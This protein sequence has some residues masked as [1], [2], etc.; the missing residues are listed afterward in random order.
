MSNYVPL[1]K[2]MGATPDGRKAGEPLADATSPSVYAPNLGPTATHRSVARAIDPYRVPNGVTFNQ[3]FNATTLMS[4]RELYK[5]S[6]LVREFVDACGM[7]VQYTV[8]DSATLRDAQLSPQDYRDLFVRVGGYSAVFVE[9]SPEVQESII[10]R[11]E[12]RF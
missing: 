9:L 2:A 3:R 10:A 12:Q 11:A 4:E 5:W 7:E 1:G 8:V 6:D